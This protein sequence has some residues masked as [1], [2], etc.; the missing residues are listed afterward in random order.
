VGVF[1][2]DIYAMHVLMSMLFFTSLLPTLALLS[3]FL[4]T[5]PGFDRVMGVYGVLVIAIDLFFIVK[6]L[7]IGT[8]TGSIIEWI[9]V[10]AFISWALIVTSNTLRV[11]L[12]T[13]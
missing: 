4:L 8:S 6:V 1:S 13:H 7:T 10:A 11:A 3:G 12:S 2:E 9:A 5:Q